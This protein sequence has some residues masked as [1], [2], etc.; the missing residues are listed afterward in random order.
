MSE[1]STFKASD[2]TRLYAPLFT[3]ILYADIA[4]FTGSLEIIIILI[5]LLDMFSYEIILLGT[6][7]LH[8]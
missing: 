6:K 1:V 5:F 8:K 4:R 3:F 7:G 2:K